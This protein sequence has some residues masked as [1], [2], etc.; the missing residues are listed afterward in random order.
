REIGIRMALGAAPSTVRAR[1]L[2]QGAT[3][4]LIGL[5]AG[6]LLAFGFA[7]L[8]SVMLFG[9]SWADPAAFLAAV[10]VLALSAL[11]ASYFP[12]RRATGVN[13]VESLRHE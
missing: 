3:L 9:L 1:V 10:G 2:R 7:R 12:A 4:A 6:S 11:A 13:P 5:G 8:L